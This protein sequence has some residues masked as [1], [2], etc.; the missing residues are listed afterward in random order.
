MAEVHQLIIKH[1]IEEVRRTAVS[2][3][4][5]MVI[6][7]A[8]QVLSDDAERMGFTYSGFALTSL[9]HKP[10]HTPTWR[11]EGHNLTLVLQAGVDRTEKSI[12][13]PYGSYARFILL[14]LQSE[15]IRSGSREIGLGRSMRIWLGS[16]GL[17][18]GGKTY[19]RVNEQ[20]R[21][22]SACT[23]MFYTDRQGSELMRRGGFVDGAI[24]MADFAENV[25]Q[26]ALWQDRVL[27]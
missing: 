21:R 27:L 12:G 25:D 5:R 6:E 2:K 10:Q 1:G 4:E 16:M 3:H 17:S 15:A 8:Y 7:T 14:F 13:L 23:L 22:I 11:R 19:R 9:P 18:I 24:T 20:A 26:P